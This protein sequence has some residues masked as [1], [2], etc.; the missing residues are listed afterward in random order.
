MTLSPAEIWLILLGA[1]LTVCA[2]ILLMGAVTDRIE[3]RSRNYYRER[4]QRH[5][6]RE[7]SYR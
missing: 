5:L 4:L 6:D 1:F 3:Q 2:L 7:E